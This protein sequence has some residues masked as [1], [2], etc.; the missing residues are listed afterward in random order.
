[1]NSDNGYT[2]L[3]VQIDIPTSSHD[4]VIDLF[5]D[6][7]NRGI[8]D[9]YYVLTRNGV[10]I[11]H[12]STHLTPET[13]FGKRIA[14]IQRDEMMADADPETGIEYGELT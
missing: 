4:D 12:S 5:E 8:M 9:G 13:E 1:M 6:G 7:L 2:K 11:I 14:Q 3:I 10:P